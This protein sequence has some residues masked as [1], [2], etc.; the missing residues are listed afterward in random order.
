MTNNIT[1]ELGI[2]AEKDIPAFVEA[3]MKKLKSK[4]N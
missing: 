1:I 2:L 4:N 3:E